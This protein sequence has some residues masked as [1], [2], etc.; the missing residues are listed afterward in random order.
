MGLFNDFINHLEAKQKL[1]ESNQYRIRVYND[2]ANLLW[3]TILY[4]DILK[5]K[6]EQMDTQ[7]QAFKTYEF[8]NQSFKFGPVSALTSAEDIEKFEKRAKA[9][10]RD[11]G[12]GNFKVRAY[13]GGVIV[14]TF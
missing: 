12:F 6:R 5:H 1:E 11:K 2:I 8:G 7:Q 3:F 13:P 4:D 10:L 14:G 9:L